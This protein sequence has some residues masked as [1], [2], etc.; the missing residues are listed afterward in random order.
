M[1]TACIEPGLEL[2]GSGLAGG[3][4][5]LGV[6]LL[7]AL[8]CTGDGKLALP[9][10]LHSQYLSHIS[11]ISST[12]SGL[13]EIVNRLINYSG[14]KGNMSKQITRKTPTTSHIYLEDGICHAGYPRESGH[15]PSL[16][17]SHGCRLEDG[18]PGIAELAPRWRAFPWV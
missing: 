8:S 10:Q 5:R 7:A 9:L 11:Q 2:R 13:L 16:L 12:L 15:L 6:C 3:W 14:R 18:S 17:K 1:S 4:G